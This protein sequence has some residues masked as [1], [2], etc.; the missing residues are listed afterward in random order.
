MVWRLSVIMGRNWTLRPLRRILKLFAVGSVAAAPSAAGPVDQFDALRQEI[1]WSAVRNQLAGGETGE[2]IPDALRRII[3]QEF[4]KDLDARV[5]Y[6]YGTVDPGEIATL[7]V[8]WMDHL[9]GG[10]ASAEEIDMF[11]SVR[12]AVLAKAAKDRPGKTEPEDEWLDII[13]E[14]NRSPYSA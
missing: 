11:L 9:V 3:E 8:A 12:S 10:H 13:R 1:A 2:P 5:E 7:D 14:F 6:T 4:Q